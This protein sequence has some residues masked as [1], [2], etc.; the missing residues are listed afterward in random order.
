MNKERLRGFS[1]IVIV[2][3]GLSAAALAADA[4]DGKA[5]YD[6]KCAMCHGMNGVAKPTAKGSANLND[7]KYQD[8]NSVEAIEKLTTDGKG[9]MKG[10][11]GK[12]TPEQINA[13]A[14]YVKTLK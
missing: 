14:T 8:A 9:T 12:L 2:I 13:I 7:A 6:A 1:V 3:V 4:P 10:Y 5:L 11:K